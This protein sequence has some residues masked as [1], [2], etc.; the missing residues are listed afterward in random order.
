M[1]INFVD[2]TNDANHYT[3]PP[4]DEL[5]FLSFYKYTMLSSRTEDVHQMFSYFHRQPK[6]AKFGLIFFTSLDFQPSIFK[7]QQNIWNMK[8][9]CWV[10][11]I[12]L[13]S[14]PSLVKLGLAPLRTVQR[15][16]P[17]PKIGRHKSAKSSITQPRI[18]WLYSNSV[19]S[20]NTWHRKKYKSSRS[21]GERSK[22]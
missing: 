17:T 6:S 7:K 19:Q 11:M 10:K 12:A 8:L 22:S 20:L 16:C 3:K 5:F 15:K 21:W 9:T 2:A 1:L 13:C 18:T 4:P 14:L